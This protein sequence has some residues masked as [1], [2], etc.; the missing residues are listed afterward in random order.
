M[1]CLKF[2]SGLSRSRRALFFNNIDFGTA[3]YPGPGLS[4]GITCYPGTYGP[5][6]IVVGPSGML[7]ILKYAQ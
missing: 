3:A 2:Y 7:N 6:T 1:L 4:A 5:Y